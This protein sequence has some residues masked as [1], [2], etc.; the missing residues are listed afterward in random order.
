MVILASVG[1]VNQIV[2]AHDTTDA[3][4]D[5]LSKG[6]EVNLVNGS[7]VDV[8]GSG[9]TVVLLFVANVMLSSRNHTRALDAGDGFGSADTSKV[10]VSSKAFPITASCR[11]ATLVNN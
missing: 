8:G 4:L 1:I 5:G 2:A 3:S 9:R 6:P 11:S 7:V 10:R